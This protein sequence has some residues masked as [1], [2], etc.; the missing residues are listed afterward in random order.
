MVGAG[1]ARLVFRATRMVVNVEVDGLWVL[2]GVRCKTLSVIEKIAYRP[3][4]VLRVRYDLIF[5]V[6]S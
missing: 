2:Y 3:A 5:L 1:I 6:P 4:A